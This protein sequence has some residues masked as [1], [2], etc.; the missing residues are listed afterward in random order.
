MTAFAAV[1]IVL[2]SI[3][4]IYDLMFMHFDPVPHWWPVATHATA[5][6][7]ALKDDAIRVAII[8]DD[9]V[10]I[11]ED[12]RTMRQIPLAELQ[13]RL[14][15]KV[16]AGSEKKVYIIVDPH[17]PYRHVKPVIDSIH[18]AGIEDIAFLVQ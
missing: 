14:L 7:N 9:L 2:V 11:T 8:R 17:L 16:A 18:D 1:L 10:F 6:P 12:D 5:M 15:E 3:M 4:L 13:H